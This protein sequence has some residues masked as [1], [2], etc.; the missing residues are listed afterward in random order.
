MSCGSWPL[1]H[2]SYFDSGLCEQPCANHSSDPSMPSPG[3]SN[4][5]ECCLSTPTSIL[6][7]PLFWALSLSS[8]LA[9]FQEGQLYRV[10]LSPYP[11]LRAC[12]RGAVPLIA[13]GQA[14]FLCPIP[15]FPHSQTRPKSWEVREEFCLPPAGALV[16]SS[17]PAIR[18]TGKAA[19]LMFCFPS[20]IS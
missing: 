10:L 18:S 14:L 3:T 2:F 4:T 11:D 13:G 20:P 17:S 6:Y 5:N 19:N 12:G 8:Y 15:S 1:A 16:S 9:Q 7:L